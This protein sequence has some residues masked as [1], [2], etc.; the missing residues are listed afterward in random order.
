MCGAM[1]LRARG[2]CSRNSTSIAAGGGGSMFLKVYSITILLL[3]VLSLLVKIIFAILEAV[4]QTIAGVTEKSV[5]NEIVLVSSYFQLCS[6][7]KTCMR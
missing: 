4:Y 5:A 1:I 7:S 2:V 6:L 3:D